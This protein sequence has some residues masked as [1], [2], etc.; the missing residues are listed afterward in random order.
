MT[1]AKASSGWS[2]VFTDFGA[3]PGGISGRLQVLEASQTR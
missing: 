1:A 2:L 3:G